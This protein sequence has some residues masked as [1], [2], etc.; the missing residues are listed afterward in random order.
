MWRRSDSAA[1]VTI[2]VLVWLQA[3][4][5]SAAGVSACQSQAGPGKMVVVAAPTPYYSWEECKK[6]YAAIDPC[7]FNFFLGRRDATQSVRTRLFYNTTCRNVP[8]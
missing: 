5:H 8:W 1:A 7:A 3:A 2:A 4:V 6:T